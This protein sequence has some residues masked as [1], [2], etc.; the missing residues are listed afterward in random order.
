MSD[1][2]RD[3]RE[4]PP[5]RSRDVPR[6]DVANRITGGNGVLR[7]DRLSCTSMLVNQLRSLLTLCAFALFQL[8]RARHA[9]R[10]RHALTTAAM[11]SPSSIRVE[12][13]TQPA[14]MTARPEGSAERRPTPS[15]HNHTDPH[16]RYW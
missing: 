6:G 1:Q 7:L 8:A 5:V 2:R 12:R 16:T 4:R 13:R 10:Q 3:Q 14:T 15:T 11:P 9:A